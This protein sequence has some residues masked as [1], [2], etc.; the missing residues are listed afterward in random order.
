[1]NIFGKT[2]FAL[3]S[4]S[5]AS[6]VYTHASAGVDRPAPERWSPMSNTSASITGSVKIGDGAI[7]FENDQKIPVALDGVDGRFV[8]YRVTSFEN[9][10]LLNG[11]TLCDSKPVQYVLAEVQDA[12]RQLTLTM[13]QSSMQPELKAIASANGGMPEGT[14]AIFTYFPSH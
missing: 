7:Q 14:C 5:M 2:L 13:I 8:L 3:T 6:L 1:M 4:L 11:N 12:G 10:E 9:P